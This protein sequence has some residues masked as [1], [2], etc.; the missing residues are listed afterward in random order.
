ML[1]RDA[2][3]TSNCEIGWSGKTLE[4]MPSADMLIP[5]GPEG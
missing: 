5:R 1:H 2:T 4:S 3:F